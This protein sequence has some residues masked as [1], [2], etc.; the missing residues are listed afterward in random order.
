MGGGRPQVDRRIA[1]ENRPQG[2]HSGRQGLSR[3]RRRAAAA[4]GRIPGNAR[5]IAASITNPMSSAGKVKSPCRDFFPTSPRPRGTASLF[6]ALAILDPA[7]ARDPRRLPRRQRDGKTPRACPSAA[8]RGEPWRRSP[9]PA[10]ADLGRARSIP[11]P[12]A[13][14]GRIHATGTTGK[15]CP[16][17]RRR[18]CQGCFTPGAKEIWEDSPNSRQAAPRATSARTRFLAPT[19]SSR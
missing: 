16:G 11:Q 19:P 9:S 5:M 6:A 8:R 4:G 18:R 7:P 13:R 2:G 3:W 15:S 10:Q 17:V 1:P 12:P 14:G